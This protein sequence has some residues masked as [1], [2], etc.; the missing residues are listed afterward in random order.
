MFEATMREEDKKEMR[1]FVFHF[2]TCVKVAGTTE[3]VAWNIKVIAFV[4][5]ILN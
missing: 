4:A 1:S 2:L 5:S 3:V